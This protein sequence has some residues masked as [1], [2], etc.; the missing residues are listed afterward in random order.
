VI[1]PILDQLANAGGA[2]ASPVFNAQGGVHAGHSMMLVKMSWLAPMTMS[3][4]VVLLRAVNAQRHERA[5]CVENR[6]G[7]RSAGICQLIEDRTYHVGTFC[8]FDGAVS[9]D[10]SSK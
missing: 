6:R 5:L 2:P 7:R 4:P 9:K 8:E 3:I 10:T 1:R